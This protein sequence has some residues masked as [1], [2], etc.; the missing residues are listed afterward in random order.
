MQKA[1]ALAQCGFGDT[2]VENVL[3]QGPD[4]SDDTHFTGASF[5]MWAETVCAELC[6]DSHQLL[7]QKS[8]NLA[9]R[10][11][12]E[13]PSSHIVKLYTNPLV[14]NQQE[15]A[16]LQLRPRQTDIKRLACICQRLFSFGREGAKLQ[17]VFRDVVWPGL[18]VQLVLHEALLHDGSCDA[19]ANPG[20]L[21]TVPVLSLL[22]KFI[23]PGLLHS[24]FQMYAT[25]P[26][27]FRAR[28]ALH[29]RFDCPA[30]TSTKQ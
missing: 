2:L 23:K 22:T 19:A 24:A 1:Y 8:P 25:S 5:D 28:T 7:G 11:A 17:N 29:S 27:L 21:P 10:F 3:S 14:S 6:T 16:T 26:C 18:S 20:E 13:F 9:S 15:L 30:P 12:A 4:D